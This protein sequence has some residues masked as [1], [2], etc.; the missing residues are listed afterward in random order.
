MA[1]QGEAKLDWPYIEKWCALHGT[2][3]V[4]AEA[5]A[6]ASSVWEEDP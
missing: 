3:S 1:V 4:L 2:L 5:K 6:A